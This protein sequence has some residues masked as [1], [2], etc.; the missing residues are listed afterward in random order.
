MMRH[1]PD[2]RSDGISA[3]V[4]QTSFGGETSGSFIKCPLFS[5]A[6]VLAAYNFC[7]KNIKEPYRVVCNE[8]L[9]C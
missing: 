3:L 9:C 1:Y 4:S 6:K 7:S 8:D 5:R 2:L